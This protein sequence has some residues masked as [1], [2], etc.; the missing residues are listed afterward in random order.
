M[1]FKSPIRSPALTMLVFAL[2]GPAIGTVY[3][4]ASAGL[5]G[6][7]ETEGGEP[8]LHPYLM[9][10]QAGYLLGIIPALIAGAAV[11]WIGSASGLLTAAIASAPVGAAATFAVSFAWALLWSTN[12]PTGRVFDG[13]TSGAGLFVVAG[14]VASLGCVGIIALLE[15][16]RRLRPDG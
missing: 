11:A 5:F 10:L 1:R 9:L 6:T 12:A 2:A 14:A 13:L 8:L 4:M 15:S 3:A 7:V 16:A